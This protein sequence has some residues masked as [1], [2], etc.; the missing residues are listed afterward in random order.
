MKMIGDVENAVEEELLSDLPEKRQAFRKQPQARSLLT[1]KP[2]AVDRK[3]TIRVGQGEP[4]DEEHPK[5]GT[6][7]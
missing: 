6:L 3:R 1:G 7:A 5:D 4:V 2:G